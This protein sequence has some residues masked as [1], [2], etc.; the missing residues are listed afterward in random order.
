MSPDRNLHTTED[1]AGIRRGPLLRK[2]LFPLCV[3]NIN[4]TPRPSTVG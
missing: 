4:F 1:K 3:T 2:F